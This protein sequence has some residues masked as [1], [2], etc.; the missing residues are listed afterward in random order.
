M[1]FGYKLV[2]QANWFAL[3]GCIA[4]GELFLYRRRFTGCVKFFN[5]LSVKISIVNRNNAV[6]FS[7]FSSEFIKE[8][9]A[10]LGRYV[11]VNLLYCPGR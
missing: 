7:G 11:E 9:A 4:I 6:D 5:P 8:L 10:G 1:A 3:Y 2:I